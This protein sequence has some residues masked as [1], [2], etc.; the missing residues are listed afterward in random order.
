M[1][2]AELREYGEF[3][4]EFVRAAQAAKKAGKTVDQFVAEWSVPARFTGYPTP[5]ANNRTQWRSNA[6]VVWEETK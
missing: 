4:G 6:E 5:P 2:L 3:N 1:S